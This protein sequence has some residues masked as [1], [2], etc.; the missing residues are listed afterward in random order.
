MEEKELFENYEHKVWEWTPQLY[1]LIALATTVNLLGIMVLSQF[2]IFSTRGCDTPYVGIVCQ[3]MDS[4]YIASVFYGKGFEADSRAYEKTEIS[5]D[6][7]VTII[8]VTDQLKYPDGI[9]H[10]LDQSPCCF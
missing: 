4:A 5:D 1:K 3:A 7:V 2:N 9:S 6:E 10:Q 8:D